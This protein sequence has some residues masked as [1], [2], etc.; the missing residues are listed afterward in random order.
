MGHT[1]ATFR[2]PD[3]VSSAKS[4]GVSAA[5][6]EYGYEA[7]LPTSS[8]SQGEENRELAQ[9]APECEYSTE[10][11]VGASKRAIAG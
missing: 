11:L 4:V 7:R 2:C 5:R 3:V 8:K 9:V 6:F 1:I 10:V